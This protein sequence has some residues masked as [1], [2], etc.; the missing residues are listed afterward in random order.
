MEIGNVDVAI[1]DKDGV[2][3][4]G[5]LIGLGES[6][7]VGLGDLVGLGES[8]DG[9]LAMRIFSQFGHN[10]LELV[11]HPLS[12]H[13]TLKRL[14]RSLWLVG[15]QYF[16]AGNLNQKCIRLECWWFLP[17]KWNG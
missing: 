14:T 16:E 13:Q 12:C 17:A 7:D 5:D 3:G 2:V 9:N 11:A 8:D 15:I 1:S 6:D 4:L 10:E